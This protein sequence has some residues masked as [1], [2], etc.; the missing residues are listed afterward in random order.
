[1]DDSDSL[2][3]VAYAIRGIGDSTRF[4]EIAGIQGILSPISALIFL[5][6]PGNETCP[7][8]AKWVFQSMPVLLQQMRRTT[9]PQRI[10]LESQVRG[11]VDWAGTH[12]ARWGAEQNPHLY[13]CRENSR[14]YDRPENQLLKYMLDSMER[15][16]IQASPHVRSLQSWGVRPT[17]Q[18]SGEERALPFVNSPETNGTID[19]YLAVL[20]HRLRSYQEHAPLR[21][22]TLPL[23]LDEELLAAARICTNRQY[24]C[25]AELAGLYRKTIEQPDFDFWS[26]LLRR[27][28]PL[29]QLSQKV[30]QS[31][32][33]YYAPT[34][35]IQNTMAVNI[36]QKEPV[37]KK[38]TMEVTANIDEDTI[39]L[40][41]ATE[42]GLYQNTI[43]L[44]DLYDGIVAERKERSEEIRRWQRQM[45]APHSRRTLG[46]PPYIDPVNLREARWGVIWPPRS[47]SPEEEVH[48]DALQ[49]LLTWRKQQMGGKEPHQFFYQ[50][51]WKFDDFLFNEQRGIQ[52]GQMQPDVVPYYLCIVAS[53]GRIPWEFQQHLDAEYAVGRLWFDDP[54][55]C[56][57]YVDHLVHTEQVI[58]DNAIETLMIGTKHQGDG[59]TQST[60]PHLVRPLYQWLTEES[61][62]APNAKLW[63]GDT[64][65]SEASKERFLQWLAARSGNGS[66]SPTMLF[67]AG[68][69]MECAS[70][71]TQQEAR[72]GALLFQDWHS[73][74]GY[75]FAS[76][77]DD[78]FTLENMIAYAFACYSAGT[79]LKEDWVQTTFFQKPAQLA[80]LPFVS[81]LPQK[82]LAGGLSAFIGHVSRVWDFSFRG[83]RRVESQIVTFKSTLSELLRGKPVG[84]ALNQLN[85]EGVVLSM[86]LEQ[87]LQ[88]TS[89][90][91]K[92]KAVA[93]WLARNDCLGNVVLGDPAARLHQSTR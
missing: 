45:Q 8:V 19:D 10:F 24:A 32:L 60:G 12:K 36:A 86:L 73:N 71:S 31:L 15:C 79:P 40:S 17:A 48:R 62:L 18:A 66:A 82:L 21:Q 69:G 85:S 52:V 81:A 49:P 9:Q 88:D 28:L 70:R 75:L 92:A 46:I 55:N 29:P 4:Q 47:L 3:T 26:D 56:K 33:T 68:H 35:G 13:L 34:R 59:F 53:P 38:K 50:P 93:T 65:G 72:Q 44:E 2:L 23:K 25:L 78:A 84:H 11:R 7:G 54:H 87:Q 90:E 20:S 16:I 27:T 80:T 39:Q 67:T 74:N 6:F 83:P 51:G 43:A 22:V 41:G 30:T 57:R 91:G 5:L 76:E 61:H 63:L 77:I 14:N 64:A 1:M 42:Q 58:H 89:R 37:Q